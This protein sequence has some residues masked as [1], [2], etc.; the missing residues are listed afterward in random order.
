[1]KSV[2]EIKKIYKRTVT[3]GL[4]NRKNDLGQSEN[5]WSCSPFKAIVWK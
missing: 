3:K 5:E 1:M 2:Q 4:G